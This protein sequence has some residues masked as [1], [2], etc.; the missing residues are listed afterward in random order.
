MTHWIK[1][2]EPQ[3][4]FTVKEK[5]KLLSKH[6]RVAF[7]VLGFSFGVLSSLTMTI[8]VSQELH[9]GSDEHHRYLDFSAH[10]LKTL[11]FSNYRYMAYGNNRNV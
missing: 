2:Q 10:T 3:E 11:L 4:V 9:I 5:L 7:S 6:K 1:T 8:R